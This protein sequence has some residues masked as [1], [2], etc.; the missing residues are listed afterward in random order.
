MSGDEGEAADAFGAV[1]NE[2]RVAILRS[3]MDAH[4]NDESPLT[5]SALKSRVGMR[6]S[7][8]FNYHL[9]MLVGRFVTETDGYRLTHAGRKVAAAIASG[10]AH[11]T[12]E[13]E[14]TTVDGDCYACG[15]ETLAVRYADELVRVSCRACDEELVHIPFPP[16]G[17]GDR[18]ATELLTAFDRWVRSWN[19]LAGAGVCPE[20]SGKV[21]GSLGKESDAPAIGDVDVR[22][23]VE[24]ERCWVRGFLPP[25]TLILDHPAVLSFFWKHGVDGRER[26]VWRH[27]WAL[28]ASNQTVVSESPLRVRVDIVH[29]GVT[30]QVTMNDDLGVDSV[31][32]SRVP[33]SDQ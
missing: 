5:Y 27:E 30:L 31:V 10:M 14:P 3:L 32:E 19:R 9:Q 25:G 16:T 11:R 13:M 28:S 12:A 23:I 8:R 20:C 18:T 29:D 15:N 24:C 17:I 21:N 26:P 4:R 6:D 1:G 7:G 33:P 2:H 22:G